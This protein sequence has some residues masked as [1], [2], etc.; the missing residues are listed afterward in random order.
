MATWSHALICVTM[1]RANSV[2]YEAFF[3]ETGPGV[4]PIP[5]THN[6]GPEYWEGRLR[7]HW[8]TRGV[9]V[10]MDYLKVRADQAPEAAG[11]VQDPPPEACK[12]RAAAKTQPESC[13]VAAWHALLDRS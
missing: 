5:W 13:L 8:K 9:N 12:C 1:R 6:R 3:N 10:T 2:Y 4:G 11:G 7:E